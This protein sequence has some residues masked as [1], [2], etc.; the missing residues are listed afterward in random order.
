MLTG[1]F[2]IGVA[3]FLALILWF[4]KK[5]KSKKESKNDD[6]S[7]LTKPMDQ[8]KGV[9]SKS[10]S[11]AVSSQSLVVVGSSEAMN[12]LKFEE[13]LKAPAELLGRGKHGSLYKVMCEN[14][15]MSLTVKRIKDWGIT[16]HDFKER[17]ERL[18][19]LK[20]PNVLPALAFYSSTLEKLLV[21]EYQ[22][23]GSLLGLVQG[24]TYVLI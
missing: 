24:G 13:L 16:G 15:R 19:E 4:R 21:Y 6:E 17:M 3:L 14:P 9:A 22:E 8:L 11:V 10:E 12:G 20:H 23:N 7:A 1:Y 18:R 2:L 5:K